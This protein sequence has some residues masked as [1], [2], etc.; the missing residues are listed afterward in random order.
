MS[1]TVQNEFYERMNNLNAYRTYAQMIRTSELNVV[2]DLYD[3]LSTHVNNH[4]KYPQLLELFK[5][6]LG[7]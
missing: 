3:N 2:Q 1:I 4:P 5:E 7:I 6:R